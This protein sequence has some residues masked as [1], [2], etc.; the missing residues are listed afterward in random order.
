MITSKRFLSPVSQKGPRISVYWCL[1][2]VTS[3]WVL[4]LLLYFKQSSQQLLELSTSAIAKLAQSS[5]NSTTT[6][7]P[8]NAVIAATPRAATPR[9]PPTIAT[10][11]VAAA[12]NRHLGH[13]HVVFSTDC[14][15]YQDWQTLVMFQSAVRVGQRGPVT[16]IASGCSEDK[17]QALTALYA[18][19]YPQFSAHFTP[20]FKHDNKTNRK[21][22]FYNK[23]WGLRHWLENAQPA[24]P[25]DEV[26]VLLDPDMIFLR[27]ITSQIRGNQ[28]NLHRKKYAPASLQEYVSLGRPVAQEYGLGAPWTND[29]HLKFNRSAV[30]PPGSPC[31]SVQRP[32]G[33]EHY[34]VGPPYLLVKADF[35][36]LALVWTDFVP[37]V[38][39]FYPY[40]LAEMYAYSMAAAHA[41]LPHLQME[42]YMVSNVEAGAE[43]WPWVDALPDVCLPAE[44]GVFFPGRPV[45]SVL[46]Y[47]QTFSTG[48]HR[49]YKGAHRDAAFLSCSSPRMPTLAP[50]LG[51]IDLKAISWDKE[52]ERFKAARQ[53]KRGGFAISILYQVL[54]WTIEHYQAKMC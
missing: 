9:T 30:C 43:G 54:N 13:V 40:L 7:T 25:E 16:R 31:L 49:F 38:Y 32:F 50:G 8:K 5:T 11:T 51:R 23:P 28:N 20:D 2:L 10:T 53:A 24:V 47:C 42:Q 19:L 41:G 39:A 18:K 52:R 29:Q 14:E 21:Y 35:H 6:A 48:P 26:V 44:G 46:H 17:K 45:P 12:G 27:P 33:E 1:L 22:A 34:S 3:G 15:P 4:I 36:R 37:R